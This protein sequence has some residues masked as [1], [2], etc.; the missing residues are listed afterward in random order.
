MDE[1][2]GLQLF[3]RFESFFGLE[4]QYYIG[5]GLGNP[6]YVFQHGFALCDATRI[7]VLCV[8]END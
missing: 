5:M 3:E 8:A 4:R 7:G 2:T 6:D 1:R